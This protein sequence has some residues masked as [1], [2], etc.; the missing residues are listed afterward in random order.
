MTPDITERAF[1]VAIERCAAAA[2]PRRVLRRRDDG[3][4]VGAGVRRRSSAGRLPQAPAGGLRPGTVPDP[5]GCRGLPAGH[6]AEGVGE[7][8]AAPRGG[9][10][11][12]L[13]G[14]AFARDRSARSAR[15][16]AERR[17]GLGLQVPAGLLPAGERAERGAAT[18]ARGQPLRRG[19]PAPLQREG[20]AEPRPG[21]LSE[22]DPDLHIRAEESAHRPGCRRC[23]SSVPERPRPARAT[24][25]LRALPRPLS[26]WI[27]SRCS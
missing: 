10:E 8:Q 17:E 20:R 7:A 26:R 9:S 22:R 1:E 25:C 6:P 16:A 4:G 23:D 24:F 27:R 2:R 12:A 13:P 15:R 11:A 3:A 18:P 21:A 5:G 14:P 19:A